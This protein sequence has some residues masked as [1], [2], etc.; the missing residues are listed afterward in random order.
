MERKIVL[1][2]RPS[3]RLLSFPKGTRRM[4]G[5]ELLRRSKTPFRGGKE[6]QKGD[7]LEW[8]NLLR[9]RSTKKSLI[10]ASQRKG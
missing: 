9:W 5:R 4:G 6:S 1:P 8:V 2:G 3:P 7:Y 10:G